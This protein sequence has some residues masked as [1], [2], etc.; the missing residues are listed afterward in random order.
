LALSEA[1]TNA[2]DHGI[3]GLDSALKANGF[4]AYE[5]ARQEKFDSL[6]IGEV[7]VQIHLN[8]NG[9]LKDLQV[10]SADIR[11]WDSGTGFDLEAA[12]GNSSDLDP[13]PSGR[14]L[15]II[16]ALA[17]EVEILPPGNQIAFRIEFEK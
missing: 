1:I 4:E 11:V 5:A 2:M 8:G 14:G 7:G 3:L 15:A 10:S 12:N 6:E 17:S 16:R 9:A 13:V